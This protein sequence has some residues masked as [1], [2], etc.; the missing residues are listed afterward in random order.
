MSRLRTYYPTLH[1]LDSQQYRVISGGITID[2]S[3][4]KVNE[5]GEKILKA[6]S[7]VVKDTESGLYRP[8]ESPTDDSFE[9]KVNETFIIVETVY[10]DY[11]NALSGAYDMARIKED[12]LPAKIPEEAKK[13]MPFILFV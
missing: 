3:K 11:G 7:L 9:F 6:G 1:F 4:I 8:L 5:D 10:G 13:A 2:S 12:Y